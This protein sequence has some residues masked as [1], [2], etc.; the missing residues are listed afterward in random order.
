VSAAPASVEQDDGR[1]RAQV[2]DSAGV[3]A[4]VAYKLTKSTLQLAA[5]VTLGSARGHALVERVVRLASWV[6]EHGAKAFYLWLARLVLRVARPELTT[7]LVVALAAD[8]TLGYVE[9]WALHKRRWWAPWLIVVATS[10]LVPFEIR[11]LVRRFTAARL[12]LVVLNSAIVAYL[13]AH[14]L[15]GRRRPTG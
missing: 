1:T 2:D 7:L 11:E 14:A 9:G 4:I 8:A 3:R 10:S 5:A 6:A 13:A 12:L 15:R